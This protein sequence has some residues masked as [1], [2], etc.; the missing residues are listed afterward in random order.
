MH[1]TGCLRAH[2][3]IA[4]QAP[5][6]SKRRSALHARLPK[7]GHRAV[8]SRRRMR[9]VDEL[10]ELGRI[11]A[12][13]QQ[14]RGAEADRKR[15]HGGPAASPRSSCARPASHYKALPWAGPLVRHHAQIDSSTRSGTTCCGSAHRSSRATSPPPCRSPDFT[16]ARVA[17]VSAQHQPDTVWSMNVTPDR[18]RMIEWASVASTRSSSR[19][20]PSAVARSSSPAKATMCTS[21][22]KCPESVR[23]RRL[24][25]RVVSKSP[26]FWESRRPDS[27]R[28]PLHYE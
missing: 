16:P 19:C 18:S 20:T 12:R 6:R 7:V 4:E 2:K 13:A 11:R 26:V 25:G 5:A 9:S 8:A 27:N 17:S 23:V 28:G 15:R 21:P 14:E 22:P 1:L 10:R 24:R 3:P